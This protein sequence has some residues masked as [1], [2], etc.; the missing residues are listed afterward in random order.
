[1]WQRRSRR[2]R[3]FTFVPT[4]AIACGVCVE[5]RPPE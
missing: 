5:G 4:C 2:S 1:L 3:P